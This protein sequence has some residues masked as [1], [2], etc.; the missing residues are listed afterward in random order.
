MRVRDWRPRLLLTSRTLRLTTRPL[1]LTRTRPVIDHTA[2]TDL[3]VASISFLV[4]FSDRP[5]S[6]MIE[7]RSLKLPITL[8]VV[9]IVLTLLLTTGWVLLNVFR[10]ID[11]DKPGLYWALLTIGAICFVVVLIGIITYLVL[12]IR[13]IN[14][15]RRQSNFIDAVTHELKT[16]IASLKLLLQTL[17]TKDVTDGERDEFYRLMLS[18]AHRLDLM[19]NQVLAAARLDHPINFE[20]LRPV[21]LDQ[22]IQHLV[23]EIRATTSQH[24]AASIET[25]LVA[26]SVLAPEG[27]LRIVITNLLSNAIKYGGNPPVV[28]I[29][30]R[31]TKDNRRVIAHFTDNGGGIPVRDRS[32]IFYRFVRL[33]SELERRKKGTGLGLYLVKTIVS[34]LRG[35]VGVLKS[36][37]KQGTVFEL[38]LPAVET[39]SHQA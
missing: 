20:D 37:A 6:P 4:S 19:I 33:G 36:D 8:G 17:T 7:R 23:D 16:P 39:N 14:L 11:D 38:Q 18:D 2:P 22:L 27:E 5:A 13:V 29:D 12:S 31:V 10:A 34:R 21:R 35:S 25:N 24:E 28:R 15:T 1:R 32:R 9:L 3:P 26:C 30:L